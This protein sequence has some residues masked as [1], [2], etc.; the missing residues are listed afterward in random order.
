[1]NGEPTT[2]E[3]FVLGALDKLAEKMAI[4]N[5]TSPDDYA[6][7]RLD[8]YLAGV[9]AACGIIRDEIFGDEDEQ[10]RGATLH[11]IR[12]EDDDVAFEHRRA[13]GDAFTFDREMEPQ[14]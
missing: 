3:R 7:G 13:E 2:R 8:G 5:A 10:E 4:D 1:M 12:D 9:R 11:L 6:K 14:S